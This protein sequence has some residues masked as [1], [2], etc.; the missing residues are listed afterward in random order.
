MP[1]VNRS[2][3]VPHRAADMYALV[4]DIEG[5]PQF[6]PWC[7][8]ATVHHRMG[9]EVEASLEIARGPVR[10]SFRTRN[11]MHPD[12]HIEMT[13]VSGPF[14]RL[15]GRWRFDSLAGQGCRVSL[16]LEFAFASRAMHTLLNPVFSRIADTLVDSFC[17]RA[18]Q[19][20]G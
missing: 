13:L 14:E 12:Q 5:Y 18:R 16:A 6:L 20:Y 8:S 1:V 9:N 3:L 2:A 7:R 15:D 11:T 10:K 19:H 17:Q 4:A